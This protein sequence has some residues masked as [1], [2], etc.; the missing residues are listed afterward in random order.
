MA[1][2]RASIDLRE[3]ALTISL[4]GARY[5]TVKDLSVM[6]GVSTRSAGKIM[7]KMERMGLARKYSRR[8][9]I[10]LAGPRRPL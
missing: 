1:R 5:V 9:Y 2:V 10:I 7:A 3:L 6:L 4:L 8:A